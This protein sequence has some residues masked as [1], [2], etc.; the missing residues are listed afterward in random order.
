M[1]KY[2]ITFGSAHRHNVLGVVVNGVKHC[3]A[4]ECESAE[5]AR[6]IAHGLFDDQWCMIYAWQPED[7]EVL[8]IR[9]DT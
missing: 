1:N 2:F 5:R 7:Y 8:E 4:V 3:V 6:S 9:C